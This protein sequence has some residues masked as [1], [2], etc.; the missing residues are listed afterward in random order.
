MLPVTSKTLPA[1]HLSQTSWAPGYSPEL[2]TKPAAL[3]LAATHL[4]VARRIRV[5]LE[6]AAALVVPRDLAQ[7][8]VPG[9]FL[10]AAVNDEQ[11]SCDQNGQQVGYSLALVV[12]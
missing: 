9:T 8:E 5:K 6:V 3:K 11:G 10:A 7:E 12:W 1:L 2:Q 4:P